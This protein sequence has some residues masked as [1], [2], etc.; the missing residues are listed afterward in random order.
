VRRLSREG[1]DKQAGSGSDAHPSLVFLWAAAPTRMAQGERRTVSS[2]AEK[3]EEM[4]RARASASPN[5]FALFEGAGL[6]LIHR[7]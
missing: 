4:I 7:T 2:M 5:F 6:R 3:A 1:L